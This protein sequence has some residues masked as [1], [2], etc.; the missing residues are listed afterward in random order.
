MRAAPAGGPE[1]AVEFSLVPLLL[2]FLLICVDAGVYG[3]ARH[4]DR[5]LSLELCRSPRN[6]TL[7]RRFRRRSHPAVRS[8]TRHPLRSRTSRVRRRAA[9]LSPR[10]TSFERMRSSRSG[11]VECGLPIHSGLTSDRTRRG[12][13]GAQHECAACPTLVPGPIRRATRRPL[14]RTGSGSTLTC[15]SATIGREQGRRTA[16]RGLTYLGSDSL[17]WPDTRPRP[18]GN[19]AAARYVPQRRW[20][21]PARPQIMSALKR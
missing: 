10:E 8:R 21:E 19:N 15:M 2:R 1:S 16:S 9:C 6:G 4:P 3:A 18:G 14:R 13:T 17:R 11:Q 7:L 5:P 20:I 12:C